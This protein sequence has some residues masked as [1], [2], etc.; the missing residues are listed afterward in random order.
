MSSYALSKRTTHAKERRV[1]FNRV[2]FMK[3]IRREDW[4]SLEPTVYGWGINDVNYSVTKCEIVNGTKKEVWRCP[5]YLDWRDIIKRCFDP[6]EHEKLPTYKGCTISEEWKYLSKF[7]E[8]VDSQP[9]EDW[10]NCSPDK[11][12]L[13]KGNKHYGPDTVI[14]IPRKLNLFMINSA[15]IRGDYMLGVS[16]TPNKSKTN[17]YVACCCDPFS[18]RSSHVGMFSTELEA[19]KAWQAKKHEYA[20]VYAAQ[21]QDPRLVKVLKELYAPDKDWTQA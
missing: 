5:Y 2:L 3:N 16:Y 18:K 8:W 15:S 13:I 10:Q 1:A 21:Q 7:I 9:N 4:E 17:P 6:K 12:F 19:H 11:D 14:Y 20:L